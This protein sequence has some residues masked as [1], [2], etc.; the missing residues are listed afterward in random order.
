MRDWRRYLA[1]LLLPLTF[2]GLM[3]LIASTSKQMA[4]DSRWPLRVSSML[5]M[6]PGVILM[7]LTIPLRAEDDEVEEADEVEDLAPQ[8]AELDT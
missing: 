3:L 6:A 2:C 8:H 5:L 1:I 7:L 4:I